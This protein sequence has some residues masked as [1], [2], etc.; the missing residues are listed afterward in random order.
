MWTRIGIPILLAGLAV[1]AGANDSDPSN[2]ASTPPTARSMDHIQIDRDAGRIDLD[3]QVVLRDGDW[4]ELLAC[5]PKSREH[6][7]ILTVNAR[8]SHIHLALLM[9]GLKP[10]S[11]MN[12]YKEKD[13]I[14]MRPPSGPKVAISLLYQH[15]GKQL[16]VPAN[17]WIVNQE[18]GEV[19]AGNQW[20]FAGSNFAEVNG[21]RV[22]A[23]DL[24]GTIISLVNFGDD[25]L[26]RSTK[27]TNR[28]DNAVW[29][30]NTEQIPPEGTAVTIRLQVLKPAPQK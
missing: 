2:T 30:A 8:P 6:E 3:A 7:S 18:T 12:W 15:D 22:Y 11:P 20:L 5:A 9:L 27:V 19:L 21:K 17:E 1:F 14:V 16:E 23:A 24:N 10:G 28:D 29:A 25:I 13:Q 4:L 26:A